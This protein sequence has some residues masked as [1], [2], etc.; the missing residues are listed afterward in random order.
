MLE[1]QQPFGSLSQSGGD[2]IFN[3]PG[4]Q[5]TLSDV[6]LILLQSRSG[7]TLQ[8]P[9]TTETGLRLPAPQEACTRGVYCLLW[10]SPTEW[11]IELPAKEAKSLQGTLT[12]RLATSLAVISDMSDAFASYEVRG[13]RAAEA[14][15]SGCRV[16][17]RP[18]AF[19]ARR[20]VRTALADIP[21]VL[22]NPGEPQRLRCLIDRSFA[23]YLRDWL[24][25]VALRQRAASTH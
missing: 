15:M 1:H 14:L 17:L 11:L 25:D 22:W 5:V 18:H 9:V 3:E 4:L 13:A 16:D 12:E 23:G 21:A 2:S 20:V 10:L 6:G 7:A 24:V 19:P 8:D